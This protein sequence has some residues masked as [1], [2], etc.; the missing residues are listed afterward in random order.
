MVGRGVQSKKLDIERVRKPRQGMPVS[1]FKRG[2]RPCHRAP[3]K[4]RA[5]ILVLDHITV[6]VI[7][8]ESRMH[9]TAVERERARRQQQANDQSA[10]AARSKSIRHMIIESGFEREAS[11]IVGTK[12][13]A[14]RFFAG[15]FSW[16]KDLLG[17]VARRGG[18]LFRFSNWP[19]RA[20]G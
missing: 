18:E 4:T 19:D 6:I 5:H 13:K 15:P 11:W 10:L 7:T 8:Q 2:E 9:G 3:V 16:R 14:Q 12:D 20:S 1:L 17:F